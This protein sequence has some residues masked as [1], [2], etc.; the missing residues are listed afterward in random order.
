MADLDITQDEADALI[1]MEKHRVDDL[2][3]VNALGEPVG[4]VDT[5][6]LTRM[7]WM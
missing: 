3:V 2:V 4:M 1:A 7:K 5:Q 6:D